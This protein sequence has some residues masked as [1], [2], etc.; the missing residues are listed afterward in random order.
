MTEPREGPEGRGVEEEG[1]SLPDTH[2]ELRKVLGGLPR[3]ASP[4]RDLWG[5][6]EARIRET[7]RGGAERPLGQGDSAGPGGGFRLLRAMGRP[8]GWGQALAA[9]LVLALV[10]SGGIWLALRGPQLPLDSGPPAVVEQGAESSGARWA[11]AGEAFQEYDLAVGD[12]RRIL[13]EAGDVLEPGTVSTLEESLRAVE[14]ALEESREA[15]AADPSAEVF[16]RLLSGNLRRKVNV[17]RQAV[18]TAV[19]VS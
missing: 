17:I 5:G 7:Q 9:G 12:L 19:S 15:L 8:L 11:G 13:E 2:R 1:G 14:Q 6:I 4:P 16:T 10:S 3:Q 18:A